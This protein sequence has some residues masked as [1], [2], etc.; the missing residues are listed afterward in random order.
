MTIKKAAVAVMSLL[1]SACA[2]TPPNNLGVHDGKLR[3]CP[4]SP[5][6]VCSQSESADHSVKPLDVAESA[7]SESVVQVVVGVIQALD[8]TTIITQESGYIRAAFATKM[9]FVD[10]VEF[11]FEPATHRLHFRS[12]SRLGHSDMGLNRKRYELL[13][14]AL[15]EHRELFSSRD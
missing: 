6:C 14:A 1:L 3:D 15:L 13:H 11:Y 10:D 8:R 4:D 7:T 5:N 2:G 12:A 9:G